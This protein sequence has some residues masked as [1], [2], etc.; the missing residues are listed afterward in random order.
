MTT[1][2][3][4]LFSSI[5]WGAIQK[6]AQIA[7]FRLVSAILDGTFPRQSVLPGERELAEKLGITRPTLREVLQ[8]LA[9]DGWLEIHQG[10]PTRVCDFWTEG[11]LGVLDALADHLPQLPEDL[12]PNLLKVRV[13]IAPSYTKAAVDLA[14][15]DVLKLLEPRYQLKQLPEKFTHFDWHLQHQLAILGGNPIFVMILN[16]FKELFFQCAPYYFSI[17]DAQRHSMQYYHALAEVVQEND[18]K[19]AADLTEIVMQESLDF[20]KKIKLS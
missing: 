7:E 18:A 4:D 13:A 17:M 14:Q 15:A 9:R 19:K 6:P 8:R 12:V 2:Q 16:S 3:P 5:S 10:K 11:R 1:Y 20:W